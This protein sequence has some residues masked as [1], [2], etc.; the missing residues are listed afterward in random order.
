MQT[1]ISTSRSFE[2]ALRTEAR[3]LCYRYMNEFVLPL[4]LCP[5]AAPALQAD[6]VQ[7]LVISD[8]L[9]SLHNSTSLAQRI[10]IE[11]QEAAPQEQ[12]ELLLILLPR[13]TLPR[14]EFDS[15]LRQVR[16]VRTHAPSDEGVHT[17]L[18]QVET[19]F[20]LAAFHP[21][22]PYDPKSPERLIPSL[23]RSPDPLL[24][25][26]RTTSLARIEGPHEHGTAFFN[27]QNFTR[28]PS[29]P[30]SL[31]LRIARANQ[32]TIEKIG[33]DAAEEILLSILEDRERTYRELFARFPEAAETP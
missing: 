31:R 19:A 17:S 8:K 18:H 16:E 21:D 14:L 20:A 27:L 7:I 33:W 26:V 25:A 13:C 24:Q 2:E 28:P 30:E 11:L 3:R 1:D 4:H 9:E 10:Q 29:K 32:Q 12:I 15:F 23:R 5:W 22:A 6:R